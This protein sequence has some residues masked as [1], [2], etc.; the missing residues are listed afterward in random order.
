MWPDNGTQL[1]IQGRSRPGTHDLSFRALSQSS[2]WFP[3]PHLLSP[4]HC[5]PSVRL[6]PSSQCWD[7]TSLGW[8][9]QHSCPH[10]TW[11][12]SAH[13]SLIIFPLKVKVKVTQS[14]P[15]LFDPIDCSPWNSPGQNTGVG[16]RFLLQGIFPT[17]GSHPG[18]PHCRQILY[19]LS[20]EGSPT[21]LR[22]QPKEKKANR[23]KASL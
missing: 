21:S 8:P 4:V 17:Q 3:P 1:V 11:L 16:S 18:L 20:H 13:P 7:Y 6:T 19:Q 10:P 15:A 5:Q 2:R 14:C 9:L 12:P 23:E 22:V